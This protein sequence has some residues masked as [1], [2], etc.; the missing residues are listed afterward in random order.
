LVQVA[1]KTAPLLA[2]SSM[3]IRPYDGRSVVRG[4]SEPRG[5]QARHF[6]GETA[7]VVPFNA[8][9]PFAGGL[10]GGRDPFAEFGGGL[11]APFGSMGSQ[12]SMGSIM[13]QFED[14][15]S[16][17]MRE[18]GGGGLGGNAMMGM[19]N[20]QYSCQS[21]AMCSRVG[22]DGQVHTERFA[23]SEVG[24]RQQSMREAQSAYS[25]SSTGM[26]KMGLERQLGN[27]AQ[28]MVR[29]RDRRTM[30]ERSTEMFK[31]MDE[32]QRD[33]FGQDF[34][35]HAQHLPGHPRFNPQSLVVAGSSRRGAL[36]GGR[37]SGALENGG[38]RHQSL[39]SRRR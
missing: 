37:T 15:T 18:G 26:D 33:A 24:N 38:A 1:N 5:A 12:S 9:S 31:G 23:N 7:D 11:M 30:E 28:K 34:R 20:G 32:S 6:G 35:A 10:L 17:M 2:G 29:E 8:L 25:N 4:S 13:K 19:G 3:A 14:M 27:R 39:P 16:G 36:A 21:F 22:P